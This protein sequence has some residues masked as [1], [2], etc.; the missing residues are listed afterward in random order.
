MSKVLCQCNYCK[1]YIEEPE[2][3]SSGNPHA[4]NIC[5]F[6]HKELESKYSDYTASLVSDDYYA[7]ISKLKCNPNYLH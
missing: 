2:V 6:C 4:R 3:R 1:N 5:P 7:G